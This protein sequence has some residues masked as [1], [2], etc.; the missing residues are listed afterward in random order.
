MRR[1]MNV[2]LLVL[3]ALGLG[4]AASSSSGEV[5]HSCDLAD[6]A[7]SGGCPA[8]LTS[9]TIAPRELPRGRFAP[10][11][12]RLHARFEGVPAPS[13]VSVAWSSSGK[14][15][16]RGLPSCGRRQLQTRWPGVARRACREAMV[17]S[18]VAQLD[19]PGAGAFAVP[20]TLFNGGERE[21][22][23]TLLVYGVDPFPRPTPVVVPVR[24]EKANRQVFGLSAVARMPALPEGLPVTGF[25]LEIQRTFRRKGEARSYLAARCPAPVGFRQATFPIAEVAAAWEGGGASSRVNRSCTVRPVGAQV[26]RAGQRHG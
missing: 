17:G 9:V 2:A 10:I 14:L 19:L 15:D 4:A 12:L 1:G 6:L 11:A 18:G 20:L 5:D 16:L 26:A 3:L 7:Q 24:I 22:V 21:G 23:A 25:A 13:T 8:L